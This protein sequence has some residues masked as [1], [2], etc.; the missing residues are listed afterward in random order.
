MVLIHQITLGNDV[1]E[2][3]RQC[4]NSWRQLTGRDFEIVSWTDRR[5][6]EYLENCPVA[7][8]PM[9]VK[10]SRNYGEVSDI[11]RMAIA[12]SYGGLYVDWDVL[13]VDAERFL[14]LVGALESTSCV[15]IR[16][17]HTTAPEFSCVYDNSLF[18][19]RKGNPLARDFLAE[20]NENYAKE[21]LPITPYLT[22]PLAL[23]SFLESHPL[24]K[25]DC[26]MVDT[27]D[28]YAFDYEDVIGRTKDHRQRDVLLNDVTP[29]G[30]PAIHFWTHAWVPRP[31]WSKRVV[32]KV[33]RT[34]KKAIGLC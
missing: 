15:L 25:N 31:K 24:Y 23:T 32:N 34:F 30:A 20:I 13:L 16:D 26:R 7:E 10:M 33:L 22:G 4:L 17:P 1:P 3:N 21:P 11:L 18:Y 27:R 12:Y 8:A 28:I 19:I 29:G 6:S 9:L 5:V 14:G 2:F